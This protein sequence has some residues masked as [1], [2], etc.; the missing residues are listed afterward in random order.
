VTHDPTAEQAPDEAIAAV[1]ET[2]NAAAPAPEPQPILVTPAP[3]PEPQARGALN[4][5]R[6]ITTRRPA[7]GPTNLYVTAPPPPPLPTTSV[8]E[9]SLRQPF[10]IGFF[11]TVG[12]LVAT[13]LWAALTSL[14]SIIIIIV[15]SL[16]IALG[17][18]PMVEWL[19][20]RRLPRGAAVF[21]VMLGVLLIVGLA[22]TALLPVVSSQGALLYKNA[23]LYVQS[24]RDN[25]QLASLDAQYHFITRIQDALSSGNLINTVW[26][27]LLGAGKVVVN[28]VFSVIVTMVLT[29][30]FLASLPQIKSTIYALSPGS[31][32]ERA[33]FL[34]DE[35]FVS[36]GGYVTGMTIDVMIAGVVFFVFLFVVGLGQYALALAFMVALLTYIP[37]IGGI[38]NIVV[39]SLVGFSQSIGTGIACLVFCILYQQID[40]YFTQPRLM[41][42]AVKVPG[43][44]VVVAALAGGTSLGITGAVMAVPIA[45][46]LL[47]LYREV[48]RPTLDAR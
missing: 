7:A 39:V 4:L 27:G 40:S 22:A 13:G 45:A 32:R 37:L 20:R 25:A 11:A 8:T 43:A 2:L 14:Q 33:K 18:N 26:S 47:L 36:V 28:A 3:T 23:P 19:T 17:L 24:L 12:A 6:R 44:L 35:V 15:L 31:R 46:T 34:A 29:A 42:R 1:D 5:L 10:A 48:V 9:I 41:A 21:L 16:F 30:Y 38:T